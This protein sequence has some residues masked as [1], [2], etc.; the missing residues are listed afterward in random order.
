MEEGEVAIRRSAVYKPKGCAEVDAVVVLV[1]SEEGM[2]LSELVDAGG[3]CEA[4]DANRN[5]DRPVEPT[6]AA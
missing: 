1:A 4:C 2:C 6:D 5:Q 3:Q